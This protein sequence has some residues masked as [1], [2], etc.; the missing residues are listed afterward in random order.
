MDK[1]TLRKVQLAQL[2]ILKEVDRVCREL[3]INYFLEWGTLLGAVRHGAFIPWD[4]DIDIGML[5]ADYERF[6][7]EA[8]SVIGEKYFIQTW[9]NDKGF[10]LPFAKVRMNNTVYKEDKS[11]KQQ[12]NNGIYIDVFPHDK[13]PDSEALLKKQGK[14]FKRL[15]Q[16]ILL[17]VG[18]VSDAEKKSAVIRVIFNIARFFMLIIPKKLLT[19]KFDKN[20]KMYNN[21]NLSSYVVTGVLADY[22]RKP[23]PAEYLEEYC[24]LQFE[25]QM[26]KCPKNYDGLLKLIYGDYMQLPPEDQRENKHQI[27]EIKFYEE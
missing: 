20:I 1:E 22:D 13:K 18:Y 6:V 24:E 16:L 10:G 14:K 23:I 8:G 27:V 19:K 4:D 17:K 21:S 11:S 5:R 7:K 25:D 2:D 9:D 3:N 26:F 15:Y 12:K